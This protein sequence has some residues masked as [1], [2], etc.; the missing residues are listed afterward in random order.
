MVARRS[1]QHAVS[2]K[3]V[4][5]ALRQSCSA[6]MRA[7]RLLSRSSY[8]SL[9]AVLCAF[10]WLLRLYAIGRQS[11]WYDE[12]LSV[13]QA[14]ESIPRLV[15]D[16]AQHDVHPPLYFS[17]LHYW[18]LAVG[19]SELAVRLLSATFSTLAVAACYALAARLAGRAVGTVVAV[20]AAASPLLIYYGQ[21]TRMYALLAVLATLAGYAFCRAAHGE[22]RW[23]PA[24]L[25]FQS[26]ALW[27]QLY[28]SLLFAALNLWYVGRMVAQVRSGAGEGRAFS[29]QQW[30]ASHRRWAI[31]QVGVVL[32]F[33][34]WLPVAWGNFQHY[35]SPGL[36]SS[37][38]TVLRRTVVVFALGYPATNPATPAWLPASLTGLILVPALYVPFLLA[39]SAGS[40]AAVAQRRF[41][42]VMWLLVPVV[43][44]TIASVGKRDFNARYLMEA[45]PSALALAGSGI[46]WLL[47]GKGRMA[48]GVLLALAVLGADGLT[49][50]R[51]Y[52]DPAYARD[53]NRGAVALIAHEAVP[54]AAVVLDASIMEPA[55]QYYARGR[56]P[57][58]RLPAVLPADPF[59]VDDYLAKFT[60]S[61]PQVWLVLWQDYYSD[62]HRIVWDW[63]LQHFYVSDWQEF[64]GGI[65]VLRF[66]ALPADGVQSADVT[67]GNT[68]RLQGYAVRHGPAAGV[69]DVD[70]YWY[71][72]Q[73]PAIDFSIAAHL[74]D[75]AGNDFGNADG[76]PDTGRLPATSW[77]TGDLIHT[78][79]HVTVLPWTAPAAYRVQ[80]VVYDPRTL[81]L[82]PETG[83]G[84]DP[85]GLIL[86]IPMLPTVFAPGNA[87]V[88]PP[89]ALAVNARVGSAGLL[90]GYTL[91][92][93]G[94]TVLLTLFW[95]ASGARVQPLK[96]FVQAL[97]AGGRLIASG[98]SDPVA[99]AMPTTAWTAGE[100][101]RDVHRLTLPVGQRVAAYVVGLYDP[102]SGIRL[103]I[104]LADGTS[105]PDAALRLLVAP[106]P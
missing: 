24:Y 79:A 54:G 38:G 62:P 83:P 72:I 58:S 63:L 25:A 61:R 16:L 35:T 95:Q 1:S 46:V 28:A 37:L 7:A 105:A 100:P 31:S 96:V 13:S 8:R 9:A 90:A 6:L 41:Y 47:Q 68:L 86:P 26:A 11:L 20:C 44:I 78:V 27:T 18:I 106:T 82:L 101:I 12:A 32:V 64:H 5:G 103:P 42:L 36:G 55:F 71:A 10:A 80:I 29:W 102:A 15:V 98:D 21:E 73:R 59:T 93:N 76:P 19:D 39:V 85:G 40:I 22:A 49:V 48:A 75:A 34:P 57:I 67:L 33:L 4:A 87:A 70:L 91:A 92:R 81:Q 99:G 104:T 74:I 56:W 43:A 94:Q 77:Q 45:A 66:D 69:M 50:A 84:A 88:L 52:A 89:D 51:I 17:L 14:Q 30:L 3:V 53:D 2:L 60:S 65:K 23:W 97:D